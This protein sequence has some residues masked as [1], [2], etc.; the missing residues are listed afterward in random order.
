MIPDVLVVVLAIFVMI[1][2]LSFFYDLPKYISISLIIFSLSLITWFFIADR[3][4]FD[5]KE[6]L[7]I[8]NVTSKNGSHFQLAIDNE[9]NSIN[10]FKKFGRFVSDAEER[11]YKLTQSSQSNDGILWLKEGGYKLVI[12]KKGK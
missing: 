2:S 4:P 10:L 7:L 9:G 12:K 11:V 6:E 1:I 8:A 5:R 3:P